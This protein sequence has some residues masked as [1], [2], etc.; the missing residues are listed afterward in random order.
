MRSAV[1][2]RRVRALG[3]GTALALCAVLVAGCGL[4][5]ESSPVAKAVDKVVEKTPE[6]KLIEAAPTASTEP[7]EYQITHVGAPTTD[8]NFSGRVNGPGKAYDLHVKS[9]DAEVGTM[10]VG[11]LV[12]DRKAWVRVSI[13]KAES[14]G[15]PDI[16]DKWLLLDRT[17]VAKA[18]DLPLEWESEDYDPAGTERLV[19]AVKSAVETAPGTYSGTLDLVASGIVDLVDEAEMTELGAEAKNLPFTA[20]VTGGRL[21]EFALQVPAAG[22]TKAFTYQVKYSGYGS[23]KPVTT[24]TAAEATD[25]P[26]FI[27][28]MFDGE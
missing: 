13:S 27:Y 22:S 24:P 6:E 12:V 16:P 21:T 14:L 1:K 7:H 2:P 8:A 4:V 25:A 15:L 10:A 20:T 5:E 19:K 3:A 9:T 28:E 23:P 11:F 18:S 26:E 17:K